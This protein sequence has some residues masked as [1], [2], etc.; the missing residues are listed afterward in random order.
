MRAISS[1]KS[2]KKTSAPVKKQRKK[3]RTHSGASLAE[4]LCREARKR[5]EEKQQTYT[6]A[7]TK[8]LKTEETEEKEDV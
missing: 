4:G 5:E 8:A 6:A 3:T 2:Y 7:Q 1:C